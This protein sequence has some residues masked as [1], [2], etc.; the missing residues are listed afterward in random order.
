MAND[1]STAAD[2]EATAIPPEQWIDQYGDYLYRYAYSRLRDGNAAEEVVQET[3]LAGIRYAH[4]YAGTGSQRGW[5]LGILKRKIIDHVRQRNRYERAGSYVDE[6]D[7]TSQLFDAQ[8]NWKTG[9]FRWSPQPD[10][11]IREVEFRQVVEGCL[12]KLPHTQR[13]VFQKSVMDE[14]DSEEI[15]K[16][17][18]ITPSNLW[19][20]MHRARLALAK[21][22]ESKWLN[23]KEKTGHAE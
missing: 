12:E 9:A 14:K 3:F 21:C 4:Q 1:P 17:L 15:C 22:V 2:L 5:L 8:G 11:H 6:N 23:D 18:D 16:E 10:D 19:V 7:P 20:R 13:D